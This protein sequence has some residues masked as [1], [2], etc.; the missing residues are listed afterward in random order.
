[1]KDLMDMNTLR[2]PF[3]ESMIHKLPQ[4]RTN[5]EFTSEVMN[6]IYASVEPEIEPEVYRRQMLWAYG[7]I[8]AGIILIAL[9]FFAI[10]PFIDFKINLGNIQILDIINGTL[11]LFDGITNVINFIKASSVQIT[12]FL[13][14]FVLFVIERLF[15]RGVSNSTFIF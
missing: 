2:D 13:S 12:I 7:S 1:M 14:V 6:Q 5:E 9:I 10:W 11:R 4:P 8:G 15:R 3:L